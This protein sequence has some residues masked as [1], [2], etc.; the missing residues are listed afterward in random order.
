MTVRM[1]PS[2]VK[3]LDEVVSQKGKRSRQAVLELWIAR[4][5]R[6]AQRER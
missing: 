2:E 4:G 3:A 1:H 5:I 6:E